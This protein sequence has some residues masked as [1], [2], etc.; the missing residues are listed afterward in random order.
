M[1]TLTRD[2][3][4]VERRTGIGGSESPALFGEH[5]F[6]SAYALWTAKRFPETSKEPEDGKEPDPL[7]WGRALEPV[8]R[9]WYERATG[10]RVYAPDDGT[11]WLDRREGE[12]WLLASVDGITGTGRG[13]DHEILYEGKTALFAGHRWHGDDPPLYTQI[14]VQQYL[15]VK[16]MDLAVVCVMLGYGRARCFTLARHDLFIERLRNVVGEWWHK[17]VIQGHEPPVDGSEATRKALRARFPRPEPGKIVHLQGDAA[18]A[19][20]ELATLKGTR[21]ALDRRIKERENTLR[22][23]MGDANEARLPDGTGYRAIH[24]HEANIPAT[25]RRAHTQLRRI[26]K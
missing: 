16:E 20:A 17:H 13:A 4:L 24:I 5:P 1:Q 25:T 10:D 11:A 26:T 7:W 12:P 3:W 8:M 14:Q 6:L 19:A 21:E 2:E 22:A 18:I 9:S 23:A 15:D